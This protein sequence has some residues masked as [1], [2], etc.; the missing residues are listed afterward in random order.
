[1][2]VFGQF[3]KWEVLP[4]PN[5]FMG[6]PTDHNKPSPSFA[7]RTKEPLLGDP[8]PALSSAPGF[9]GDAQPT[10]KRREGAALWDNNFM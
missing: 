5:N 1:M 3:Y 10:K 9:W 7:L 6:L 4:L 2:R 8:L